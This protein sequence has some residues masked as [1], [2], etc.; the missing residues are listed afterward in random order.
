MKEKSINILLVAMVLLSLLAVMMIMFLYRADLKFEDSITVNENGVTTSVLEVK[1]LTLTPG[2]SRDYHVN[3]VCDATGLYHIY[4]DYEEVH[5]GGMKSFVNV[6][7]MFG[8]QEL[9]YGGLNSLLD[10][11]VVAFDGMLD[12]AEPLTL[13]F[14]YEMPLETGNEAMGTSAYFDIKLTIRKS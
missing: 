1:D 12:H 14:Y 7:I 13:S 6:R 3:L 4:I 2:A 8:E 9:Y 10:G 11:E 5:N